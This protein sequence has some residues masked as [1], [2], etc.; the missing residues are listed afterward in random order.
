MLPVLSK[1]SVFC[2]YRPSKN[3]LRVPGSFFL[4]SVMSPE[5]IRS[6]PGFVGSEEILLVK[7]KRPKCNTVSHRS[8]ETV[9]FVTLP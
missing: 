3:P 7:I 4:Y 9:F 6:K 2:A 8:P 1:M 5:R